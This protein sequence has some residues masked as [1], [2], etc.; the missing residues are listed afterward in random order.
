MSYIEV[1]SGD[2]LIDCFETENET[3]TSSMD[4]VKEIIYHTPCGPGDQ[5]FVEVHY[6]DGEICRHFNP[7]FVSW[8][9]DS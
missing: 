9:E 8:K 7:L 5:H 3:I 2:R 6:A 4:T 1:F